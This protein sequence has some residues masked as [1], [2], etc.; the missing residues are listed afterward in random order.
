[1]SRCAHL[2]NERKREKREERKGKREKNERS[3]AVPRGR[4]VRQA[5][6]QKAAAV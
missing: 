1:M 6:R 5:G 2:C 3:C 4:G